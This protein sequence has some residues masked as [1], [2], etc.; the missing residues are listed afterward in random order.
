MSSYFWLANVLMGLFVGLLVYSCRDYYDLGLRAIE[1]DMADKLRTL[2]RSSKHLYRYLQIWSA[3]IIV[4]FIGLAFFL[5]SPVFAVMAAIAAGCFPYYLLRRMAQERKQKIEDQLADAMVAFSGAIRAGLSLSQALQI[6]SEQ[7]PPPISQEF[8][9]IIG[10]YNLGKPLDRTLLEAKARLKS[11]NFSLFAASL[12]ASRASGGRL[13]ETVDR[14]AH[15]VLEMQR[16]ERKML[17]ETAQARK[18]AVYMALTPV[19][20]VFVFYFVDPQNTM[21]LFNTLPGQ[22]L[23]AIAVVLNILAYVWARVIMNPDI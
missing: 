4:Q 14:I 9:Q 20:I 11:E 23:V 16:L 7:C 3:L 13:N 12:L 15:S 19:F 10:E 2:R 1:R 5:D 8:T 17:A 18:A 22:I 21:R 6:L